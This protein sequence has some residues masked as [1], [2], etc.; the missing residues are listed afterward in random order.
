M[1]RA[2]GSR[3]SST[4][5]PL[6]DRV[7][8]AVA[9]PVLAAGGIGTRARRRGRAR[10]GRRRR[11]DRDALRRREE[12]ECASRPGSRRWSTARADDAVPTTRFSVGVPELPHRVL[13]SSILAAS[14]HDADYVGE[15]DHDGRRVQV[16]R[17][18][19]YPPTRDAV[20]AIQAMP[21]YAGRS[22][23]GVDAIKPPATSSRSSWRSGPAPMR[24]TESVAERRSACSPSARP[25]WPRSDRCQSDQPPVRLDALPLRRPRA[26]RLTRQYG[27]GTRSSAPGWASTRGPRWSRRSPTP[28][29]SASSAPPPSRRRG[30]CR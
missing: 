30:C 11:A 28:A 26:A 19:S 24:P 9:V 21:F 5:L 22:V 6:L 20:G 1:R 2:G 16:P 12:S 7:L 10:G 29:V 8:D 15:I 17:F 4:L 13:R 27:I 18:A 25:G 23:A 14:A 3:A